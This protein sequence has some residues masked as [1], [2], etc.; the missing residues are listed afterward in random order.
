MQFHVLERSSSVDQRLSLSL[1]EAVT[2]VDGKFALIHPI[3]I[4]NILDSR[5]NISVL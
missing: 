1:S 4:T 2:F 5:V 3:D